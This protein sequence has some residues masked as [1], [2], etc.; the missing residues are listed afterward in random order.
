MIPPEQ[1]KYASRVVDRPVWSRIEQGT[2]FSNVVAE[3]YVNCEV[4]GLVITARC[5]L[6]QAK[7]SVIN[8]IPLV[9]FRDWGSRDF[10]MLLCTQLRKDAIGK[11][12][13]VL[14]EHG[15]RDTLLVTQKPRAILDKCFDT[16]SGGQSGKRAERCK[17]IVEQLD[18]LERIGSQA[19]ATPTDLDTLHKMAPKGA[20]AMVTKCIGQQLSGY[21]FL[22]TADPSAEPTG[23]VALLREI[24]HLP[25]SLALAV[26]SGLDKDRHE[27]FCR[28]HRDVKDRLRLGP[29][30]L[31]MPVGTVRSPHLEHLMQVFSHLYGR[32]GLEDTTP[33]YETFVRAQVFGRT[34]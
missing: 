26:A 30:D 3:N 10:A 17:A 9:P 20:E 19:I 31:A 7:A 4:Y 8:Y 34:K 18:D 14:R 2:I 21:Y 12:H 13:E 33:E 22:P 16:T 29:E 1:T 28:E 23:Y 15:L 27:Q 6:A 25:T 32:I 24:Y 5:D 11:F